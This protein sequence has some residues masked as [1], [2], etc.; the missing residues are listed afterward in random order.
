MQQNTIL[1]TLHK[2]PKHLNNLDY[3][4][5]KINY[6]IEYISSRTN[7]DFFSYSEFRII[8]G[9]KQKFF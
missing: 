5:I 6:K 7:Y 9:F 2:T 4:N 8:R 3:I 1:L